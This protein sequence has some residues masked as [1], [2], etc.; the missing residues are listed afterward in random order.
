M[1]PT[2]RWE[3]ETTQIMV[4]PHGRGSFSHARKAGGTTRNRPI[5]EPA[6]T[7]GILP[8]RLQLSP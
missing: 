3:G 1:R 2:S 8:V 5:L 4:E 6:E 7:P